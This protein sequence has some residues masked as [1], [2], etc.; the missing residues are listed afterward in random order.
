LVVVDTGSCDR[1]VHLARHWGARIFH[2]PWIDDFAAARNFSLQRARGDWILVLDADEQLTAAAHRDLP[3]ALGQPD[4]LA[5][6]LLRQEVESDGA[7]YSLITRLFRRR[8][9][10][11]FT[12]TYH[13]SVDDALAGIRAQEPHWRIA[14]LPQVALLHDGYRGD[15]RAQKSDFAHRLMTNHLQRHPTDVYMLSKLGAL[16]VQRGH[17]PAGQALLER[18]WALC[19]QYPP[20]AAICFELLYHL[21]IAATEL[22]DIPRAIAH[23]HAALQQPIPDLLKLPAH[24]NLGTLAQQQ[25]DSSTAI[26]HYRIALDLDPSH[27]PTLLNLGLTYRGAGDIPRAIATYR[28]LVHCHP[29]HALGHQ[30]L[31]VAHWHL[32]Q[33]PEAIAAWQ[34]AHQLHRHQGNLQAAAQLQEHLTDLG[35]APSQP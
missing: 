28:H 10:L 33:I 15:R 25:G 27:A 9:D 1:T 18:G 21:G 19:Q 20:S 31:G 13:E 24:H 2:F 6:Q 29:H 30:N 11:V 22:G 14:A 32:G 7:P 3:P 23:Y 17:L 8:P 12:G 16:E 5:C 4:V 26:A 34:V 35:V